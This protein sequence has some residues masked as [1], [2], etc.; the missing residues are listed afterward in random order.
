MSQK[1]NFVFNCEVKLAILTRAS[2]ATHRTT[3]TLAAA[4]VIVFGLLLLFFH[5]LDLMKQT[6]SFLLLG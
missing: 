1:V 4:L 6:P 2:T 3:Y 5:Y